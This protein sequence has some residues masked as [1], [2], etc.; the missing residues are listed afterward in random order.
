MQEIMTF[1]TQNEEDEACNVIDQ[2]STFSDW[3]DA[4]TKAKTHIL[5]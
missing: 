4:V 5:I 2:N 3:N 1:E